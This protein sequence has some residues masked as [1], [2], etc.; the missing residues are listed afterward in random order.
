[1]R[2]HVHRVVSVEVV[3]DPERGD[4]HVGRDRR[5]IKRHSSTSIAPPSRSQPL[6]CPRKAPGL[7]RVL[8]PVLQRGGH[9]GT[10]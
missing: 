6:A 9:L 1:M 5:D 7:R 10:A 4:M 2:G 3:N 8:A